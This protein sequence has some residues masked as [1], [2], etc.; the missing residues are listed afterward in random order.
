[1]APMSSV[2][3]IERSTAQDF[4]FRRAKAGTPSSLKFWSVPLDSRSCGN[5]RVDALATL[6]GCGGSGLDPCARAHFLGE[7]IVGRKFLCCHALR[8]SEAAERIQRPAILL[9]P[10]RKRIVA[11]I[12]T[13]FAGDRCSPGHGN[14]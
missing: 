3:R 6:C 11:E 8:V 10:V 1:M 4:T 14:T 12:S 5:E 7:Q 9:E 13:P 2:P